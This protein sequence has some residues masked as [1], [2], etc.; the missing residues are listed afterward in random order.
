MV[1]CLAT[2]YAS[3]VV[4]AEELAKGTGVTIDLS[5]K[6]KVTISSGASVSYNVLILSLSSTTNINDV[7]IA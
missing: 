7:E 2:V 5:E 3:G 1:A 6:N 4:Y